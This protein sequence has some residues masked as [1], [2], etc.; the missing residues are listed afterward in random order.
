[1]TKKKFLTIHT[2]KLLYQLANR[3]KTKK[4]VYSISCGLMEENK[5]QEAMEVVKQ[6]NTK[7]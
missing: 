2:F 7:P 4:K 5:Y 1:M 3:N 6:L